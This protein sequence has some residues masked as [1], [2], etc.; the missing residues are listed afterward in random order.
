MRI[1]YQNFLLTAFCIFLD[2]AGAQNERIE[3]KE[4]YRGNE[5]KYVDILSKPKYNVPN[6]PF[7]GVVG[8]K[9]VKVKQKC[10]GKDC[11]NGNDDTDEDL[12]FGK[13]ENDWKNNHK[14]K[15]Y[16]Y[17]RESRSDMKQLKFHKERDG[18]KTT[19]HFLKMDDSEQHY[20]REEDTGRSSKKRI[21]E[22][23]IVVKDK[24]GHLKKKIEDIEKKRFD[25]EERNDCLRKND[26]I[27][28]RKVTKGR[29]YPKLSRNEEDT[30]N[31]SEEEEPLEKVK[32][33]L[34]VKYVE[35]E[36]NTRKDN[37]KSNSRNHKKL[38]NIDSIEKN[39]NVEKNTDSGSV[40]DIS[41]E[42]K[43]T[44]EKMGGRREKK[45]D[46]CK[47]DD[48]TDEEERDFHTKKFKFSIKYAH[49]KKKSSPNRDDH[50]VKKIHGLDKKNRRLNDDESD[51]EDE[52][53]KRLYHVMDD[54][55]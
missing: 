42:D 2:S 10:K 40:E 15:N 5:D 28:R 20:D 23:V 33:K 17:G 53:P 22:N 49:E 55:E 32:S 8:E 46:N 48:D 50:F 31:S 16:K 19:K 14:M 1:V 27:I 4:F 18:G 12:H 25:S 7:D 24:L 37:R 36:E 51:E 38:R 43:R 41:F 3:T 54:E 11:Q 39:V 52:L 45:N 26:K 6:R 21:I 13:E 9:K 34:K 29:I 44:C 30:K 47:S 35:S